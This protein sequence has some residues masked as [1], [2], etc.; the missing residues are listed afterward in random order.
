MYRVLYDETFT[1]ARV[2]FELGRPSFRGSRALVGAIPEKVFAATDAGGAT[3]LDAL[4]EGGF[5]GT[6]EAVATAKMG[7][8]VCSHTQ[9]VFRRST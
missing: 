7:R 5:K 4:R 9:H 1:R 3:F 6:R 8:A 2:I